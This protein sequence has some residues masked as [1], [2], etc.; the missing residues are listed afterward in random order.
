[1]PDVWHSANPLL[2]SSNIL[3]GPDPGSVRG[4][5]PIPPAR[6]F[7]SATNLH[8]DAPILG[9]SATW[10]RRRWFDISL[11]L[12]LCRWP[13]P[14]SAACAPF[15][16]VSIVRLVRL[17][18]NRQMGGYRRSVKASVLDD[19]LD[20][21]NRD[22]VSASPVQEVFKTVGAILALV[23][24]SVHVVLLPGDSYCSATRTR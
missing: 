4:E 17:A 8:T 1:M 16:L 6:L 21:L 23:Q 14:R 24:V 19:R 5:R 2:A 22:A 18:Q 9:R 10:R 12:Y 7:S 15:G 3:V 13:T 11:Y 20:P